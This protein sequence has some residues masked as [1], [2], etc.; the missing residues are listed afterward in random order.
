MKKSVFFVARFLLIFLLVVLVFPLVSA[1]LTQ[2]VLST[3]SNLPS[4]YEANAFAIDI[5]IA[6]LLF[7][8][9]GRKV[10]K[11]HKGIAVAVG[12]ALTAGFVGVQQK[13]AFT[14]GSAY[15]L[16]G[17]A[18]A[19]MI[20]GKVFKSTAGIGANKWTILSLAYIIGFLLVKTKL[21][22]TTFYLQ[23]NI[24]WLWSLLWAL[25]FIAIVYLIFT[26]GGFFH[27]EKGLVSI[28]PKVNAATGGF[29][30]FLGKVLGYTVAGP[31]MLGWA[32]VKLPF[33][34]VGFVGKKLIGL[35]GSV[36]F[37]GK[38]FRWLASKFGKLAPTSVNVDTLRKAGMNQQQID[39]LMAQQLG[40]G[41]H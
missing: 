9:F 7:F 33:K 29:G 38:P 6:A 41:G 34:A 35:V 23:D 3:L 27:G 1:E 18:I 12:L 8:S 30:N 26:I 25:W 36:P 19:L 10:F 37:V 14:F 40:G 28:G 5:L 13:Y 20:F 17:V 24:P 31:F 11:E 16:I 32:L 2:N 4:F 22:E 15:I 39:Q 21:P